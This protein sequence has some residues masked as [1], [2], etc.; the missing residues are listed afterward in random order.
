MLPNL[1]KIYNLRESPYFQD[2]LGNSQ[3][4][5]PLTLFVGRQTEA[6]QLLATIGG[7]GSSRQA[8]GGPPGVG[9]T[10]LV[11]SVKATAF[12]SGYWATD[13]V[14]PFYPE[15]TVAQVLGRVL[16]GLYDAILTAR[17]MTADAPAMQTAQQLVRVSRLQS[18]GVNLSLMGLGG[19]FNRGESASTPPEALLLDGPRIINELLKLV[20]GSDGNGVLLHLNNLENLSEKDA[21]NA[22]DI[23]RSLRDT[24]LL[25]EG[26]HVLIVGTTDAVMTVT[27][28]HT[29]VRS[30][31]TTPIIL[32][33]LPIVD[34][35]ALLTARYKH[36]RLDTKRDAIP[37]VA[38][39]A[40]EELYPLF[41][42]DLRSL[43]K[44]L[45]EGTTLL[46]G[47]T[48]NADGSI[49]LAEL[50]PALKQRYAALIQHLTQARRD[51]LVAW[52]KAGPAIEHDQ[53]TLQTL[54]KITQGT[55]STVI[56]DL[57]KDGYVAA[58]PKNDTRI[59]KYVLTG[60]SR[61]IFD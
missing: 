46:M 41:R 59:T 11:Q 42:G 5:H 15:D 3:N 20:R 37:P 31:F 47:V 51:Q 33:P 56:A 14:V 50:R 52:A 43:L 18:G 44:A 4:R 13:G 28:A 12:E 22:A 10:T 58:M 29:Q 49:P 40:I 26:L 7:S 34:V 25:Q 35:K 1:W 17:P 38:D 32:E 57:S 9:K 8:I 48:S 53:G 54:W 60:M 36:L 61:L 45:E 23:L 16:G 24:V 6:K 39:Q 19:G 55:V 21:T 27:S 30:V 2:T